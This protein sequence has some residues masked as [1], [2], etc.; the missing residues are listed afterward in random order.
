LRSG[1]LHRGRP[2]RG[3]S[4]SPPPPPPPP[5]NP[6]QRFQRAAARYPR[7][8]ALRAA[9][10]ESWTYAQL[11]RLSRAGAR[12]LA[13]AGCAPGERVGVHMRKSP[14][15]V[16]AQLAILRAGGVYVPLDPLSPPA[17][18]AALAADGRLRALI[19]DPP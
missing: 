11:E 5:P 9:D 18:A 19:A 2:H 12:R 15:A 3:G 1:G 17:R 14:L 6:P 7:R 8:S 13:A 16:A 4:V 10:G